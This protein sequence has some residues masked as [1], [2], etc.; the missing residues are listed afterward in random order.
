MM[1]LSG[2]LECSVR[3]LGLYLIGG[4]LECSVRA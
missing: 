2:K 1:A 4:K 3:A